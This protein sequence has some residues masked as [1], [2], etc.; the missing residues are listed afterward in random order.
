MLGNVGHAWVKTPNMQRGLYPG[1]WHKGALGVGAGEIQDDAHNEGAADP[2]NSYTY[3]AC[4]ESVSKVEEQIRED[5]KNVPLY[6]DVY[7][8][9]VLFIGLFRVENWDGVKKVPTPALSGRPDGR[10]FR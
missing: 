9:Q 1:S 7:K 3:K 6:S 10:T 8:R 4:P 5:E 2:R